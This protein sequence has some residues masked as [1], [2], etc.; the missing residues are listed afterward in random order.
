MYKFT[1]LSPEKEELKLQIVITAAESPQPAATNSQIQGAVIKSQSQKKA[2][3]A[4][5]LCSPYA[6][7]YSQ[8]RD[9]KENHAISIIAF[10]AD[11]LLRPPSQ[12]A[13]VD[14]IPQQL[15]NNPSV[16][17]DD[18]EI[19]TVTAPGQ[20]DDSAFIFQTASLCPVSAKYSEKTLE[21][22]N[23][24]LKVD[25]DTNH[26]NQVPTEQ[27]TDIAGEY[28]FQTASMRSANGNHTK[29][30]LDRARM[31]LTESEPNNNANFTAV[32]PK[33]MEE[34]TSV[35]MFQTA[36]MKPSEVS[37]SAASG[38][39]ARQILKE[40]PAL[41]SNDQ[42]TTGTLPDVISSL[43]WQIP[44]SKIDNGHVRILPLPAK[45]AHTEAA[46]DSLV[47]RYT[48]IKFSICESLILSF[49]PVSDRTQKRD[50]KTVAKVFH[51]MARQ[52][53]IVA[54]ETEDT[55]PKKHK[56]LKLE[57]GKPSKAFSLQKMLPFGA[58]QL[59]ED[60]M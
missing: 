47:R 34:G 3:T 7:Y 40:S 1:L 14:T 45:R 46:M 42:T 28:L 21:R 15:I 8:S 37:Y 59:E 13:R 52:S 49:S 51:A 27:G 55:S 50:K 6:V 36:G 35:F 41:L 26:A 31:I 29:E 17:T 32:Q 56:R 53:Y 30:A 33:E 19:R 54:D 2:D 38:E 12:I 20:D 58:E 39:K 44:S 9:N 11:T 25:P 43:G 48:F 5:I 57:A 16:E 23:A 4:D 18:I 60:D 22:A 10:E 24:L